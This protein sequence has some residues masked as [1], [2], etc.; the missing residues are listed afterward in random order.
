MKDR[1]KPLPEDRPLSQVE[2]LIVAEYVYNVRHQVS[3][4]ELERAIQVVRDAHKGKNPRR[5]D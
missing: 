1:A 4:D 3:S 5:S 2:V